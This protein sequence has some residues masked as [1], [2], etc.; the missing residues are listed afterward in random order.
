MI[1]AGFGSFGAIVGRLLRANGVEATVLDLNSDRVDLL[2]KLGLEVFY[3]DASRLDLLRAAGAAEARLLILALDDGEKNRE[4]VATAKKHFPQATLLARAGSRNEAY[5]LLDAGV[6]HVF[7]DK[8]ESALKLGVEALRLLG[9][10]AHQ[11]HRAAQTFRRHDVRAVRELAA[12]RHDRK[13]YLGA[14]RQRIEELEELL[15]ADLE[16]AGEMRDAGWDPE[17]LREEYGGLRP[18][19]AAG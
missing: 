5:E 2:R 10:R 11:A 6:E 19:D 7:R 9:F 13:R 14:A 1:I 12:V 15:L 4:L 3:G 17:S 16:D 8:L 18:D